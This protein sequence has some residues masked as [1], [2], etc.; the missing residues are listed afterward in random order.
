[1]LSVAVVRPLRAEQLSARTQ[2]RR[3]AQEVQRA[4]V[5]EPVVGQGA[6]PAGVVANSRMMIAAN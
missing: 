4:L 2:A 6:A 3:V 5:A 1:M